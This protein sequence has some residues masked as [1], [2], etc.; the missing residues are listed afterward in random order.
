MKADSAVREY[1]KSELFEERFLLYL[2][3]R[4]AEIDIKIKR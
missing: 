2:S 4:L 3:P 1:E